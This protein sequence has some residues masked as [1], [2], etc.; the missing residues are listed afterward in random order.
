V[1]FEERWAAG[2]GV[3]GSKYRQEFQTDQIVG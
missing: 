3:C 1:T 2:R